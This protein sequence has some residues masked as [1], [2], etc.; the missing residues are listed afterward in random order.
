MPGIASKLGLTAFLIFFADAAPAQSV[1]TVSGTIASAATHHPVAGASVRVR[2]SGKTAITDAE[3]RYQIQLTPAT[4]QLT[5]IALGFKPISQ[6]LT[7]SGNDATR[8]FELSPAVIPLQEVVTIGTRIPG[9]TATE[10]AVPVD[11]V[12]SSDIQSFGLS[13]TWQVLQR[14]I[15][16]LNVPRIPRADDHM[17]A[18]TLRGLTPSQVLV[19]I[20]GRRLHASSIILGGPIF[21]GVTSVDLNAILPSAIERIEILRDGAAAQYGSDAIAGV[22]NIVLKSGVHREAEASVGQAFSSEG[23]RTWHDGDVISS[24][25]TYG[26]RFRNGGT[27]TVSGEIL[28][29]EKTNRAYPDLRQQYFTGDP[30]NSNPPEIRSHEGDGSAHDRGFMINSD[31]PLWQQTEIYGFGGM[32]F[33]HANASTA[34]FHLPR[35]NA[36]VRSLHPDGYL[37]SLDNNIRDYDFTVGSRGGLRQWRWDFSLTGGGNFFDYTVLNSNNVSLGN[38]SPVDFYLG[39]LSNREFTSNFDATRSVTLARRLPVDISLG[40]QLRRDRYRIE[41]GD[42][43]SYRDG[44]IPILDGDS[45]GTPSPVGAQGLLGFR[46]TDAVA[47][48]R[49][50]AAGYVDLESHLSRSLLVGAAGRVEHYSDYG[51]TSNGKLSA[52]YDLLR[53]VAI[54]GAVATGFRAPS[55]ME[56]YFSTTRGSIRLINGAGTQVIV[57]TMPVNTP[58][59]KL[60]GAKPLEPETSV[61]MSAGLVI[62]RKKIPTIT[63]DYYSIDLSDRIILT[64]EFT[65]AAVEALFNAN[66][67]RGVVGGR[68]FANAID[69]RTRGIDAVANYAISLSNAGLLRLTG[70][71]NQTKTRV[72]RVATLAN[73]ALQPFFVTRTVRGSIERGQPD[74]TATVTAAYSGNRFGIN[75]HNQRY[76]KTQLL[77]RSQPLFDQTVSAKWITDLSMSYAI[78]QKLKIAVGIAN[79]FDAYPDEWIDFKNGVNATGTSLKGNFRYPGGI[80]P[81]GMNGRLVYLHLRYE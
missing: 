41:E 5:A 50:G 26:L 49:S 80:T 24:S 52:R 6:T 19:L 23:G 72:T 21:T 56:E 33:R 38:S 70:G 17:R 64:S 1:Q 8:D 12:N 74:R 44:G 32:M 68:Y 61:N 54:R 57:R 34:L 60:L 47:K 15:P 4:Y 11:V 31:L 9:R 81:F 73:P 51:S 27:V 13:E 48:S 28:N 16:S 29:R 77:D 78:Q 66:G 35:E 18:I 20:N 65:G 53:G 63:I 25:A 43:D 42:P 10:S 36:T 67:L 30:R 69:T 2:G 22:I 3:G 37:P 58:E 40:G 75:L 59:A 39:A 71:Y 46:P 76:G 62:D 7:V 55:L 14:V 79:L 45:A